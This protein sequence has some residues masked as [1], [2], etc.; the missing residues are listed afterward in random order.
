M[1]IDPSR[2]QYKRFAQEFP[3]NEPI[4]MLNLIRY[5]EWAQYPDGHALANK[6]MTG[7]E[8]YSIYLDELGRFLNSA[9]TSGSRIVFK[10]KPQ[11]TVTGPESE[12]WDECFVMEYPSAAVFMDMVKNPQYSKSIVVHRQ[13]AVADSRLIRMSKL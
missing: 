12:R 5:K 11:L 2:A 10:A 8:A 4:Q 6:K 13:A 7:K 9:S 1:S 3:Q